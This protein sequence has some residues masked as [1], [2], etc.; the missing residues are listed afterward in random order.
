MKACPVT[1]LSVRNDYIFRLP[2]MFHGLAAV[3]E[4]D[5]RRCGRRILDA[6]AQ[7]PRQEAHDVRTWELMQPNSSFAAQLSKFVD[8]LPRKHCSYEYRLQVAK[9]RFGSCVETTIEDKHARTTMARK[10][11][12]VGPVRLS[13]ANRLPN[14]TS[15]LEHGK[16]RGHEFLE[17][18]HKARCLKD[19]VQLLGLQYHPDVRDAVGKKRL[20]HKDVVRAV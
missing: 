15:M 16:I 19:A 17:N 7:D 8:G 11:H 12:H 5:A 14:M 6:C 13:L 9:W 20:K 4:E 18:F 3:N 10:I 1:L 2:W